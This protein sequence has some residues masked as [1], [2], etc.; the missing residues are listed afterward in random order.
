M[1]VPH[2]WSLFEIVRLYHSSNSFHGMMGGGWGGAYEPRP[3]SFLRRVCGHATYS[4]YLKKTHDISRRTHLVKFFEYFHSLLLYTC[5]NRPRI[6]P[7]GLFSLSMIRARYLTQP[8]VTGSRSPE[9]PRLRPLPC[10]T[11]SYIK[12]L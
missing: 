1:C 9:A 8:E 12:R 3:T 11:C 4:I 5:F 6:S 2:D 7:E 10:P